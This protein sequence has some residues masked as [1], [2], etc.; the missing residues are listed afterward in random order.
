VELDW[1]VT[2][3]NP[4]SI[5]RELAIAALLATGVALLAI[6]G[7]NSRTKAAGTA[8][9]E[10][11]SASVTP[12]AVMPPQQPVM[13]G[14][15]TFTTMGPLVAEQQAD[16]A[17]E[18][19]GRVVNIAVQIGDHVKAGQLLAQ[20]DDRSM[21]AAYDAKKAHV[22]AAQAQVRNWEAEELSVKA[23]LHRADV[24]R[25][26][27]IISEDVWEHSKYKLDETTQLLAQARGDE[28]A[29][30]ADLSTANLQLEQ[31][32]VVAPFSGIVGRSAVRQAQE[33]KEG[34]VLFWITA[35]APLHVLFTVPESV[36]GA[37]TA[38]KALELT[39]ADYPGLRQAGRIVRVSPVVDP[40]SGSVQ[41]I[42]E[43][44]HPSPLLKPGM[45]MQVRLAP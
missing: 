39:T 11:P 17:A 36:M 21:R 19:S 33:V 25:D 9:P 34:D 32:R 23:D 15:E 31:M 7:C 13:P 1:L 24:L 45:S 41:V 30:E 2:H 4:L 35:E 22:A 12:P 37:F 38:G 14:P 44:V 27:K 3:M 8:L 20:L 28:Q 6:S 18:R 40:A 16:I 29:A 42:G 26:G 10:T 43:A 5:R